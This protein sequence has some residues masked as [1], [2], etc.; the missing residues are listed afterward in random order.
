MLLFLTHWIHEHYRLGILI[1][2]I[3]V[4]GILLLQRWQ[5][6]SRP[7]RVR[8]GTGPKGGS[9]LESIRIIGGVWQK[10]IARLKVEQVPTEG[11][12][13][14]LA[15]LREAGDRHID[16]ALVTEAPDQFLQIDPGLR[17]IG[18][19]FENPLEIIARK[20]SGIQKLSDIKSGHRI[21]LPPRTAGSWVR[22]EILL[23]HYHLND[24]PGVVFLE[25]TTIDEVAQKLRDNRADVGFFGG[26]F[27]LPAVATEL[28]EG[29]NNYNFVDVEYA[30]AIAVSYPPFFAAKIPAGTYSANPPFPE[31]DIVTIGSHITLVGDKSLEQRIGTQMLYEM[32]E[33]L[34]ENRSYLARQYSGLSRMSE[35]LG[36]S[37]GGYP[38]FTGAEKYYERDKPINWGAWSFAGT[39]AGLVVAMLMLIIELRRKTFG[40]RSK[41]KRA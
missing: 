26:A 19:V 29:A 9:M 7:I 25:S 4:F 27:P 40:R 23:K 10:D 21:A 38:F 28:R 12:N 5:S 16:L 2:V 14:H 36:K 11:T 17:A 13:E 31:R 18:R 20:T 33:S 37:R 6:Y 24:E 34:F 30:N 41:T 32:T 1:A 22:V 8:I 3:L 15:R 39:A 35:D